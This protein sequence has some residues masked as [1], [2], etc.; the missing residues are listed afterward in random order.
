MPSRTTVQRVLVLSIVA[1]AF[2]ALAS[3]LVERVLPAP[4]LRH[5]HDFRFDRHDGTPLEVTPDRA[6]VLPFQFGDFDLWFELEAPEGGEVDVVFRLVEPVM[7]ERELVPFHARFGLLRLSTAKDGPAFR[8]RELALFDDDPKAVARGGVRIAPGLPATVTFAARGRELSANIAGQKLGPFTATDA[9]GQ[10]AIVVRG[11]TALIRAMELRDV[12]LPLALLPIGWTAILGA[13]VGL[14][15]GLSTG[16]LAQALAALCALPLCAWAAGELVLRHLLPE[17]EPDVA[18]LVIAALS[19]APLALACARRF[20]IVRIVIGLVP[21]VLA[22]EYVARRE[23]PRMRPFESDQLTAFFGEDSGS[24]PF[25]ALAQ[26]MNARDAV[27]TTKAD[28]ERVVFLGGGGVFESDPDRAH[29]IAPLACGRASRG[30]GG[31][32]LDGVV[33]PTLASHVRQQVACWL[34]FYVDAFPARA[35]VLAIPA[36]EG[37]ASMPA[38]ARLALEGGGDL[39]ATMPYGISRVLALLGRAEDEL[40]VPAD[41]AQLRE[42]IGEL[43]AR[44]KA[45]GT[46]LLLVLDRALAPAMRDAVMAAS[47]DLTLPGLVLAPIEE[48]QRAIDAIGDGLVDLL[49]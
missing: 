35:V 4:P 12:A 1:A 18:S 29:W 28:G 5:E 16:R 47:K 10:V 33:M 22:L 27:H 23:T 34:R 25:D 45:D 15:V 48:P 21:F 38:R 32:K 20:G 42:S 19:G 24:A 14:L 31:H 11:G 13:L 43:A 26:R 6:L 41:A 2:G 46:K 49:R 30:L 36:W 9:H 44:C 37:E 40:V 17:T 8:T 7:R 3:L 39:S